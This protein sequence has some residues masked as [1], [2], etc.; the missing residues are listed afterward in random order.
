[1]KFASSLLAAGAL[2]AAPSAM[3]QV[4]E[5][6]PDYKVVPAV[7]VVERTSNGRAAVVEIAGERIDVCM[8]D[9]Q[10][11]CIQ[12]RAAGLGFGEVPLSYWPGEPVTSRY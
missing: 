2:L 3:A 1:M 12:P 6:A 7:Q 11:N 9:R 4:K 8:N 10:D 5:P